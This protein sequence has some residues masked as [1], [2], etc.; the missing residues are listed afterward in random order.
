MDKM[1]DYD[2]IIPGRRVEFVTWIRV[3]DEIISNR[4]TGEKN[5]RRY[6][7]VPDKIFHRFYSVG[8]PVYFRLFQEVESPGQR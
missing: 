4:F 8:F 7:E 1:G 3:M 2:E 6:N 5:K